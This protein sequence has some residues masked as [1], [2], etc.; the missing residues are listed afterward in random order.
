MTVFLAIGSWDYEGDKVFGV[1]ATKEDAEKMLEKA[2][3]DHWFDQ[4]RV[5]EWE[6]GEYR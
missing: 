4:T 2:I 6:I 3:K 1:T 5:E